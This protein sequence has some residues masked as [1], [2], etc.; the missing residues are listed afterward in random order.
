MNHFLFAAGMLLLRNK[1]KLF[2]SYVVEWIEF[3]TSIPYFFLQVYPGDW[4]V[5]LAV[6]S[7]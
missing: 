6:I 3:N 5:H 2:Q 7:I 4:P 1:R